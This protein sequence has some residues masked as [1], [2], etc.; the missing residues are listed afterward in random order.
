M[1]RNHRGSSSQSIPWPSILTVGR[2]KILIVDVAIFVVVGIIIVQKL[3]ARIVVNGLS[4]YNGDHT[5]SSTSGGIRDSFGGRLLEVVSGRI[6]HPFG[7]GD[8]LRAASSRT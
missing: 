6:V 5:R 4:I 3:V 8:L 2:I 7:R 1:S